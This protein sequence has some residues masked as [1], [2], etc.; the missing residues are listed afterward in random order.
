MSRL[1]SV[2]LALK[3]TLIAGYDIT[4]DDLNNGNSPPTPDTISTVISV[5]ELYAIE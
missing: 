5:S 3:N 1:I 2:E 4:L